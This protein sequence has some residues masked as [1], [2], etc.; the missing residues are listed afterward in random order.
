M[1]ERPVLLDQILKSKAD[2][3]PSPP[4]LAYPRVGTIADFEL[5][6]A[7]DLN[8]LV[9]RAIIQYNRMGLDF[10]SVDSLKTLTIIRNALNL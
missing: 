3:G 10:V 5:F 2:G 7:H 9:N 6:T 1:A 8:E 4:L